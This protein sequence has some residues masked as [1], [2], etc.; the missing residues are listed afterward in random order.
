[1]SMPRFEF[2]GWDGSVWTYGDDDCPIRIKTIDG[3]GGAPADFV[4]ITGAGQAGVTFVDMAHKPNLITAQYQFGPLLNDEPI[5]GEAALD[6]YLQWRRA[7]GRGRQVGKFECLDTG[8]FQMVR[9]VLTSW[10][11][12]DTKNV[13]NIGFTA[14]ER[15]Q[16]RSDES[17]W[18]TDPFDKTF[19]FGDT[20]T[21]DNLGDEDSW[22]WCEI[23]GPVTRP[24]IGLLD[25]L[26]EITEPDGDPLTVAAGKSVIVQSDPDWWQVDCDGTDVSWLGE[27]WH[28]KAPADTT[29][30]PFTFT[31]TG[32][33]AA[34]S[35]RI[36]VPQLFWTAL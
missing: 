9:V 20:I 27:R 25:E 13:H 18:R 16:L 15:I 36:V 7:F 31:G 26:I 3:L 30:I 1:M 32:A 8:R 4:D 14:E 22:F 6:L 24:K 17:W 5:N 2:T 29:K 21:V 23:T 19:D 12:L 10:P 34:T 28:Q 33:T 35:I 11:P